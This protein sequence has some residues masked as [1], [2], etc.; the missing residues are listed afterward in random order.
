MISRMYK[1]IGVFACL[2]GLLFFCVA[3]VL[4]AQAPTAG[5]I[6]GQ[7]TDPSGGSVAGATVLLTTPTGAS[8]ETVT[9]KDGFY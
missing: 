2:A 5:A 6:R 9:N 8:M 4:A 3:S 7:V 1:I